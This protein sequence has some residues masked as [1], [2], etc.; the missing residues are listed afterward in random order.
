MNRFNVA[1]LVLSALVTSCGYGD[2]SSNGP[3]IS[4]TWMGELVD[5]TNSQQHSVTLT[6]L[7]NGGGV[8]GTY[9]CETANNLQCPLGPS[10]TGA[11]IR[12]GGNANGTVFVF[13]I[14]DS[15]NNNTCQFQAPYGEFLMGINSSGE[16]IGVYECPDSNETGK[17]GVTKQ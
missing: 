5:D 16:N 6:L 1:T 2:G 8:S 11:D 7:D 14:E 12:I 3:G 4:G 9:R 10:M 15:S 13:V 17:W